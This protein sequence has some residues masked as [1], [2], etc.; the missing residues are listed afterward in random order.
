MR[1]LVPR[2]SGRSGACSKSDSFLWSDAAVSRSPSAVAF[3]P[4]FVPFS[5]V[6]PEMLLSVSVLNLHCTIDKIHR[7]VVP[8]GSV[9]P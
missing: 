5:V 8:L 1:V 4:S 3:S 6:L 7:F 2:R 9:K